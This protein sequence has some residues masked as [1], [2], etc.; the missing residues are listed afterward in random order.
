M[1]ANGIS[2]FRLTRPLFVLGGL[3]CVALI[4]A[5]EYLLPYTNQGYNLIWRTRIQRVKMD[6]RLGLYK[7]GQIWYRT[8]QRIWSAKVSLPLEQRLMAVTVYEMDTEGT[9][10]QRYDAAEARY[11]G[12]TWLFVQVTRRAFNADGLFQ[13]LPEHFAELRLAFP[14]DP[15]EISRV[16]KKP[17]EMGLREIHAHAEELQRQGN[18]DPRYQVELHGKLA[19]AAL[20]ILMAGF[21]MPLALRINRSGG[22]TLALSLTLF[23]GFGYVIVHNFVLALGHNGQLPPAVAA[24]ATNG[25]FGVGSLVLSMR[26]R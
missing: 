9:I 4:C 12:Q 2:P 3:A 22:T 8:P 24:W 7:K 17:D 5:Q 21:G 19:Y 25:L 14:E 10:R 23:C 20:C 15:Q 6:P 16:P 26:L 11:D 13:G 1:R 18:P